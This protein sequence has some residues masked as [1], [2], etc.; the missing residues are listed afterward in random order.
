MPGNQ[1]NG[2]HVTFSF[3]SMF[4][5]ADP[6]CGGN[7][8]DPEG[9]LSLDLSGPF[10]RNK[11]CVYVIEQPMG[12]QIQVNFTHVELEGQSG[13][14]QSYIEVT[15]I[16]L[17]PRGCFSTSFCSVK[18]WS[19]NGCWASSTQIIWMVWGLEMQFCTLCQPNWIRASKGE[20][21]NLF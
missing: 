3:S 20:L 12:E 16:P 8:T 2:V 5:A 7:Y 17:A 1:K 11:Q 6:P 14:S 9:L 15:F 13:C 19:L 21:S 10:S 18:Q 4:S